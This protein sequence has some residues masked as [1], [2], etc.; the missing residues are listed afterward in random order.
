MVVVEAVQIVVFS[1]LPILFCNR[2]GPASG[3][4]VACADQTK[5]H[6]L[7]QSILFSIRNGIKRGKSMIRQLKMPVNYCLLK[8]FITIVYTNQ[9]CIMENYLNSLEQAPVKPIR[10]TF[11]TVLCILT[12][13]GS[14]YGIFSGITGYFTADTAAGVTQAA[15]EDAKDEITGSSSD[16]GTKMAEKMLSGMSEMMNPE[17]LKKNALFTLIAS[18]LTLIGAILMFQLKKPGF[19]M[20]VLG[21]IISVAAPFAIFGAGNIISMGIA[22]FAAFIGILFVIL[23]A[24]NLKYLK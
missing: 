4:C 7:R 18:I 22:L 15:M 5:D 3:R 14:G 9:N 6:L 23:Y 19:W 11:L 24:L 13:I 20:Y 21:T 8:S 1:C 10:P 17:N 16:A 2:F 12:F